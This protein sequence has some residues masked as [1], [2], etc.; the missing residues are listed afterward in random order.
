MAFQPRQNRNARSALGEPR[1]QV[2]YYGVWLV[3]IFTGVILFVLF[4]L[5]IGK[6]TNALGEGN[7]NIQTGVENQGPE[8]AQVQITADGKVVQVEK[9][10]TD[11]KSSD[12]KIATQADKEYKGSLAR[13]QTNYARICIGCHFGPPDATSNGPWLGNLY[14]TTTLYNGKP[15]NDA[16][17]VT[18]ILLGSQSHNL[19][20]DG[21][22]IRLDSKDGPRSGSWNPMPAGIA[23]PQQAIDI[24][25]YLK[26]Q[27][28]KK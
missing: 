15:L 11:M 2:V 24:M 14:Q 7:R 3:G 9:W 22:S 10:L 12:T 20:N 27:T 17:V 19:N 26:Q 1:S 23:T 13:G 8:V 4:V 6:G 25:L 18:F 28:S 5:L 16:N 21:V